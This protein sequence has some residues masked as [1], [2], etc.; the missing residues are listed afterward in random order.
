MLLLSSLY[1]KREKNFQERRE[2]RTFAEKENSK[3]KIRGYDLT[4]Y[5]Y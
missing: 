4:R 3:Y 1:E 2:T 5:F